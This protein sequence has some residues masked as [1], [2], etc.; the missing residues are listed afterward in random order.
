MR[1]RIYKLFFC[2]CRYCTVE[3][4]SCGIFLLF[5]VLAPHLSAVCN[6]STCNT[7][8]RKK[9]DSTSAVCS[10]VETLVMVIGTLGA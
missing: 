8:W 1:G 10:L 7:F 3:F 9:K 4:L 2:G 5:R 6:S